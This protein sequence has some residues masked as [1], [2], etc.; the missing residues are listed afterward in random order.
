MPVN[1]I[2][3]QSCGGGPITLRHAKIH[4]DESI[5]VSLAGPNLDRLKG[6]QAVT[7]DVLLEAKLRKLTLDRYLIEAAVISKKDF[8]CGRNLVLRINLRSLHK[9][10][11]DRGHF[12]L[13]FLHEKNIVRDVMGFTCLTLIWLLLLLPVRATGDATLP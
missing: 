4:Q 5:H 6:L 10:L 1:E 11:K 3:D 12:V 9:G 8:I 13:S 2:T 7:T